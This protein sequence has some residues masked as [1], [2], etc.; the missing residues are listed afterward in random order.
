MMALRREQFIIKKLDFDEKYILKINTG[1]YNIN[2]SKV[3]KIIDTENLESRN[4]KIPNK[5]Y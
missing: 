3:N 4:K 2:I 1:E 5:I